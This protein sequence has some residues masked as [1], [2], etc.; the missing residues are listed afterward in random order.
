L[1][2]PPP[3]PEGLYPEFL[4]NLYVGESAEPM[5][6]YLS[7]AD[8]MDVLDHDIAIPKNI[9]A[10]FKT[11]GY[12]QTQEFLVEGKILLYKKQRL[13]LGL[14]IE[15]EAREEAAEE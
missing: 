10:H 5:P 9:K 1:I 6:E 12:I 2:R 3:A 15:K 7:T 14:K 4:A 13:L 8:K 11:M